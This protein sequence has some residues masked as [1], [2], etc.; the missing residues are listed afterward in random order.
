[1]PLQRSTRRWLILATLALALMGLIGYLMSRGEVDKS[2]NAAAG[3]TAQGEKSG[4]RGR[5]TPTVTVAMSSR[6]DVTLWQTLP[7]TLAPLQQ[8]VIRPTQAGQLRTILFED[9]AYV[10]RGQV[11]ATLDDREVR[12]SLADA[13]ATRAQVQAQRATTALTLKRYQALLKENA[14][15]RQE[16]DEYL[17][18][19]QQYRAQEAAAESRIAAAQVKLAQMRIVAPFSGRVGLRQVSPGAQLSPN[20]AQGI[21]TLTQ[22][23]PMAVDL[24][25][26]DQITAQGSPRGLPIEVWSLAQPPILLANSR[27]TILDAQADPATGALPVRA[28]LDNNRGQLIAGQAVSVRVASQTYYQAVT[29]PLQAVQTGLEDR[30][31]MAVIQ[32]KAVRRPVQLVAQTDTLAIVNGLEAG[33]AVITDGGSRVRDGVAVKVATLSKSSAHSRSHSSA[34]GVAS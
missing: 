32:G 17:G 19:A 25:L 5:G 22:T 27:I 23:Q 15:S 34:S 2:A 18:Q 21:V 11:L 28:L 6:Q 29:V 4:R 16:V 13:E 24:G 9:G 20:D 3:N 14:V 30:F 10:K 26:P 31:V 1:M 33:I 12:A 7:G 8:V